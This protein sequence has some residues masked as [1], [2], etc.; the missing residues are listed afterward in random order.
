MAGKQFVT[1]L[2]FLFFFGNLAF[3]QEEYLRIE[4]SVSPKNIAQGTEGLLKIKITPKS[5]IKI[6]SNPEFMIR[7]DQNGNLSF[8]K[9]FFVGSELNFPTSQEN[10]GIF[11]DLQKEIEIPFKVSE[12]ALL[13]KHTLSGEIIYTAL[14][15]DNWYIKTFQKFNT[16]FV[17]KKNSQVKRK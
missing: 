12:T 3:G 9:I 2:I 16:G 4:A 11:L 13:G 17:S 8:P 15:E 1:L 10:S 14:I 6:S 7:L 5:G